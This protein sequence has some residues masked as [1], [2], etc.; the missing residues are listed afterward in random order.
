MHEFATLE[1]QFGHVSNMLSHDFIMLNYSFW[2][3]LPFVIKYFIHF[4]HTGLKLLRLVNFPDPSVLITGILP[5]N[6]FSQVA[7]KL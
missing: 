6:D 4:I 7:F 3:L 1:F 5:V 2:F